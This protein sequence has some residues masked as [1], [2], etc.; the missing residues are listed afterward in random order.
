MSLRPVQ[1]KKCN[2][3]AE[4]RDVIFDDGYIDIIIGPWYWSD[5]DECWY[6]KPCERKLVSE[7]IKEIMSICKETGTQVYDLHGNKLLWK[8]DPEPEHPVR[9]FAKTILHGNQEHQEWLLE[10]A[11]CFIRGEAMPERRG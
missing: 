5:N 7:G 6:C 9:Q 3:V 10:A 8:D 4:E 1:C 2:K 11:E